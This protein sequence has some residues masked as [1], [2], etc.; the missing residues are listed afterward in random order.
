MCAEIYASEAGD[1]IKILRAS[2]VLEKIPEFQN[3]LNDSTN[4]S[5]VQ[6]A[7]FKKTALREGGAGTSIRNFLFPLDEAAVL[8]SL[9]PHF[10]VSND[11]NE[12]I[13]RFVRDV[14]RRVSKRYHHEIELP[15][16]YTNSRAGRLLGLD[17]HRMCKGN[18]N[19]IYLDDHLETLLAK[20]R[21]AA[22]V[23]TLFNAFPD[24]M[25]KH[26]NDP[27][28]YIY[29]EQYLPFYYLSYICDEDLDVSARMMYSIPEKRDELVVLL[30]LA[31]LEKTMAFRDRKRTL[32]LD[33]AAIQKRLTSSE[34]EVGV[35]VTKF[36]QRYSD[37]IVE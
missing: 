16:I 21:K 17:Y 4:F 9:S 13:I 22:S 7:H 32:L 5:H 30:A 31:I 28:N 11:D 18:D 6:T 2:R 25:V 27:Q 1:R 34:M 12:R 33:E 20:C 10:F 37:G 19:V 26:K 24:E 29:P 3:V 35:K 23:R 15:D 8:L 36:S 14:A